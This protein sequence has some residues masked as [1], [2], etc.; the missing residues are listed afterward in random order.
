MARRE[1]GIWVPKFGSAGMNY[2]RNW[3]TS[4]GNLCYQAAEH[5]F[6]LQIPV[7]TLSQQIADALSDSNT[8]RNTAPHG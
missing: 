1:S 5:A 4:L 8:W 2:A 7:G 6:Y 3:P